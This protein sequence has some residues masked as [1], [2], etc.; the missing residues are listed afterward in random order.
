LT[1]VPFAALAFFGFARDREDDTSALRDAVGF[2]EGPRLQRG[3]MMVGV[4]AP[5]IRAAVARGG[6]SAAWVWFFAMLVFGILTYGILSFALPDDARPQ[7]IVPAITVSIGLA[8]LV[9]RIVLSRLNPGLVQDNA[10]VRIGLPVLVALLLGVTIATGILSIEGL[11]S[12]ALRV[13]RYL[14]FVPFAVLLGIAGFRFLRFGFHLLG[15]YSLAPMLIMGLVVGGYVSLRWQPELSQHFSPREVYD[16][17]NGLAA[18]GEPLAEYHV[19]GRAAAYYTEGDI[20][21]VETE[22]AALSFLDREERVWL[23]FRADDLASLDRAYRARS[24]RHLFIA[25]ARSSNVLL[26]TNQPISG[27]A[28]GNYLAD[29]I[30]DTAPTPEFPVG[31]SFDRRIELIGY[32]LEAPR[33]DRIGPGDALNIT[34][35]W[36][37]TAP[38]PGSYTIFLHVDGM[39]QR[40]NG[41]HEPVEGRYPVRLWSAGDIIVDRQ[42]LRIPANFP[43]GTYSFNIGFY[44]G[45]S[46]LEVV[47]GREDDANR[48]VAGT[49]TVR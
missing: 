30:L 27:R 15:D 28:D 3:L 13:G 4:P 12:L 41:D 44:S 48:A 31:T 32:D 40:L 20:E 46:R 23:A 14:L 22:A 2:G 16:T 10:W 5:A 11:S 18:E 38:V 6:A 1:L 26:A 43:P 37:C 29:A 33:G 21:E 7:A 19:S 42:E 35:Y 45:E 34:W 24:G 49:I 39:G 9:A 17:F 47:E 8:G 36:R 25:D